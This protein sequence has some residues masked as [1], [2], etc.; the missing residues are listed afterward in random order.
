VVPLAVL[1]TI[2]AAF[3]IGSRA[4]AGPTGLGGS[5]CPSD[6]WVEVTGEVRID[7]ID[8][9]SGVVAS[10][11]TAGLYWIEE[12]SGNPA[13]IWGIDLAGNRLA[14]VRVAG[15]TNLDWEDIALARG[16]IWV[17]DVG[18]NLQLR[19]SIAVYS[20]PE[21]VP[22]ARR[23]RADVLTLIYPAGPRNAEA[24][25]VDGK[26]RQLF[27]VTKEAGVAEVFRTPIRDTPV[28][29]RVL[30]SVIRLPLNRVT[31]ADLGPAGVII[32]A[33]DA[34]L[35]RWTAERRVSTALTR[36]PCV[37]PAGPGEAIAFARSPSGVLAI[38]EGTQPSIYL[39]ATDI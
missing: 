27:V 15:A 29:V 17:G 7:G 6:A 35:Y 8:E 5:T 20:F 10:R 26:R 34:H 13:R 37:I 22:S 36:E 39:T 25:F 28:G 9:V 32:K 11:R 30:R 23:V 2:V 14:S 38:P 19:P 1:V 16:R 31:A 33:G 18:D 4:A 12:D 21:P 3:G 24:L